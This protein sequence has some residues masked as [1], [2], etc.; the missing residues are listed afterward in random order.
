MA[1]AWSRGIEVPR[2]QE[3]N[4]EFRFLH[5]ENLQFFC[6]EISMYFRS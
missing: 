4:L 5:I 3:R 1:T 2:S 6:C